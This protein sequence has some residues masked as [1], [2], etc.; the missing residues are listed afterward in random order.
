M[1]GFGNR[2][3]LCV[4]FCDS[5]AIWPDQLSFR[6]RFSCLHGWYQDLSYPDAR[7]HKQL[8]LWNEIGFFHFIEF[9]PHRNPLNW[10]FIAFAQ[11]IFVRHR[12]QRTTS[13]SS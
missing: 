8:L 9:L 7:Y 10:G 2:F 4:D 1:L 12:V 3:V 5:F 6:Y 13:Q 11:N